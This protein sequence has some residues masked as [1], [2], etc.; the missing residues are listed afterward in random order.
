MKL[1]KNLYDLKQA[2]HVRNVTIDKRVNL[3][4]FD[5]LISDHRST[6]EDVVNPS[7]WRHYILYIDD[8]LV[9]GVQ[10]KQQLMK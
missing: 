6:L 4:G 1:E 2:H 7:L 8:L 9:T 3:L 5:L 10:K